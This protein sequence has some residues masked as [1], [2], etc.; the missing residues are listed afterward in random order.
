MAGCTGW[1]HIALGVSNEALGGTGE[2]Y[3]GGEIHMLT[4]A[5]WLSVMEGGRIRGINAYPG[6]QT[7]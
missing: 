5:W 3:M 4:L 6:D 2:E 1:D 7:K